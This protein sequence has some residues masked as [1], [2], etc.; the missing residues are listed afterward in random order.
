MYIV[1]LRDLREE[2]LP[3]LLAWAH[4]S[5]IWDY[6]PTTRK[7][8]KLTWGKHNEWFYSKRGIRLDWMIMVEDKYWKSR[9]VG[10]VHVVDTDKPYPEIGLY[11]GEMGLWGKGAGKDA[12]GLGIREMERYPHV[13][14]LHA[15]IHPE[16]KRSIRLFTSLGF[17][18]IGESR[19]EQDLYEYTFDRPPGPVPQH[20]I[21]GRLSYSPSPV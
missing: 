19:K 13:E 14:G 2:D 20:Q 12:L 18:K 11:I 15:V 4:I 6:L 16:N 17:K 3:L 8:E 5:P 9:P 10:V 7:S 1:N 21:G